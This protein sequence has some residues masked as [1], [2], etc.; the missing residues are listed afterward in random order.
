MV[1]SNRSPSGSYAL[2]LI[3]RRASVFFTT[4]YRAPA[5]RIRRRSSVAAGTFQAFEVDEDDT[6]GRLERRLQLLLFNFLVRSRRR[7]ILLT[8]RLARFAQIR[9]LPPVPS[10]LYALVA[11][12]LVVS[13][14]IPGPIVEDTVRL[15]RYLPFAAAGFALTT[16]E[17]KACAFSTRFWLENDVLPI[18]ACTMPVPVH[19]ELDL[20]RL[21]LP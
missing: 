7:H 14:L 19:A 17:T 8:S 3:A 6:L 20:A 16:L 15:F 9:R 1:P 11:S 13:T 18:G 21:D 10:R 2:P 5:A 4:R 12:A